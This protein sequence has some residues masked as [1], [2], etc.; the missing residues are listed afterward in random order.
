M[1]LNLTTIR[2][3]IKSLKRF[4]KSLRRNLV[5]S[6]VAY[7]TEVKKACHSYSDFNNSQINK[8]Y[9]WTFN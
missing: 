3:M 9:L 6:I 5:L 1:T 8:N 7:L 2:M 4:V